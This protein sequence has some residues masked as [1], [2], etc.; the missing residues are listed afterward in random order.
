MTPYA[1]PIDS[2]VMLAAST[3]PRTERHPAHQSG[4]VELTVVPRPEAFRQQVVRAACCQ[5]RRV[6]PRVRRAE[7]HL[8]QRQREH[9]EDG[10]AGEAGDPR[11]ALD[12]AAPA[13]PEAR[14]IC[15]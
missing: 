15:C 10:E 12:E 14:S 8:E 4:E 13:I 5:R 3:G 7:A 6:V 2:R 1:A 9:D 11:A